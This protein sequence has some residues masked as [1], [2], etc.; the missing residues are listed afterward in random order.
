MT[1][2]NISPKATGSIVTKFH[3]EPPGAAGMKTG[4]NGPCRLTNMGAMPI[5][6]KTFENLLLTGDFETCF[7]ALGTQIIQRLFKPWV[8]LD[9][10]LQQGQTWKFART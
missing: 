1:V 2:L 4:S 7:V 5:H 9:L 8:D 3:V 10:F 6:G